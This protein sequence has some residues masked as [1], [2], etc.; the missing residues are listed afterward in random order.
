MNFINPYINMFFIGK[1][2]FFS[3]KLEK[4]FEKEDL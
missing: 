2:I 4:S 1:N 3:G